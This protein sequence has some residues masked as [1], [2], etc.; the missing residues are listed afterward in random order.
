MIPQGNLRSQL[1]WH[2][3]ASGRLNC[4]LDSMND[5]DLGPVNICSHC[6]VG[7]LCVSCSVCTESP[8]KGM[9]SNKEALH[10]WGRSEQLD[11][12]RVDAC[13]ILLTWPASSSLKEKFG[14]AF[15]FYCWGV[16]RNC[17]LVCLIKHNCSKKKKLLGRLF[18]G[19]HAQVHIFSNLE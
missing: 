13:C 16:D 8:R 19:R 11:S 18:I 2:P 14:E 7:S 3:G 5:T 12:W 9:A 15:L 6:A 1:T 4:Q 17:S 10:V